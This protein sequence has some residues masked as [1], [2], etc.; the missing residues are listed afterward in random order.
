[1]MKPCCVLTQP[2]KEQLNLY[3]HPMLPG[4][5]LA[6]ELGNRAVWQRKG[7]C[8]L[9]KRREAGPEEHRPGAACPPWAWLRLASSD[10]QR[11][12]S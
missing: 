6:H 1:M 2:R 12:L 7:L 8:F 5:A 3:A 4:L 10:S 11:A 9:G